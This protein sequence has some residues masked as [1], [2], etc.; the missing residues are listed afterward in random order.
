MNGLINILGLFLYFPQDKSE[1]IP[2]AIMMAICGIAAFFTFRFIV[3]F[4]NKEQRKADELVRRI[5]A[6]SKSEQ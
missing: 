5:E 3:K 2:A 4:S 1:Y 6:E